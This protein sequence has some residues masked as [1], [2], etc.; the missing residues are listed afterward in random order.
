MLLKKEK[1]W[2]S[3][4]LNQDGILVDEKGNP[5]ESAQRFSTV[6]EA[7]I[8]FRDNE[9]NANCL[10]WMYTKPKKKQGKKTKFYVNFL[11]LPHTTKKKGK[12]CQQ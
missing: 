12:K 3:L 10:G 1:N 6:D 4:F 11:L 8:W 9:I 2:M 7:E 5:F